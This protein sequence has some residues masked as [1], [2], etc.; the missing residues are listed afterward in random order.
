ALPADSGLTNGTQTFTGG[1]TFNA[2]GSWTVTAT[3]GSVTGTSA[4]ITVNAWFSTTSNVHSRRLAFD[5]ATGNAYA[6]T[7]GEGIYI[8]TDN[9]ASW[10]AASSVP[11]NFD[12]NVEEIAVAP[13]SVLYA[14]TASAGVFASINGTDWTDA[15]GTG[16]GT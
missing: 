2:L 15:N 12:S 5:G 3:S 11:V 1:I 14:A 8:S 6:A 7:Q 16:A 4:S 9:G 13:G 10:S